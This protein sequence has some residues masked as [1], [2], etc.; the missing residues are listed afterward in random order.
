MPAVRS[1]VRRAA[2]DDYRFESVV[3]GIISS[4]AFRK[5]EAA[6]RSEVAVK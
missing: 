4:D 3:L 6:H 5:R 2:T 1:I